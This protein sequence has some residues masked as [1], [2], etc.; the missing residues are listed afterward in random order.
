MTVRMRLLVFVLFVGFLTTGALFSSGALARLNWL[1]SSGEA[2]TKSAQGFL[3]GLTADQK[4]K[5]LLPYESAKRTDWHFIP[6][7]DR[8]GLQI[9]DMTAE[10]RTAAHALLKSCLSE[11]GYG[12]ATKIIALE[13]LL[14]VLEANKKGGQ[15]RDTQRYYVTIFGEPSSESKW[16]LSFE[17]HHLSLNFVVEKDKVLAFSPL[18]LC[19]NP[20]KVMS[21]NVASIPLGQRVLAAEE[22][23]ALELMKLFSP[24]QLKTVLIADKA[25]AEVRSPGTAQPPTDAAVGLA[26][27]KMNEAQQSCLRKLVVTYLSNLPDDVAVARAKMLESEGWQSV[28]F[29]WAGSTK[30]GEGAYYRVQGKTFLI[31]YVNTQPD[32]AGNPANHIHCVWRN[33]TGDF[34][35]PLET[36]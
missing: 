3:G 30:T 27:D 4:S 1:A 5:A 11:V 8:K 14:R 36:K 17:G 10:Q 34:A 35:V 19:T 31:E 25:L 20:A 9:R 16:G 22:D 28:H 7:P 23:V 12:K 6:K 2:M 24:E 33:L 21:D 32:A 29:A 13:E 26:Y 15:I 18:A